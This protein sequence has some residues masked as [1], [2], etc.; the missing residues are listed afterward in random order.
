MVWEDVG[1]AGAITSF[2]APWCNNH[3]EAKWLGSA[4]ATKRH[5]KNDLTRHPTPHTTCPLHCGIRKLYPK[6]DP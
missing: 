5:S 2:I 4:R 3:E 1:C 6:R